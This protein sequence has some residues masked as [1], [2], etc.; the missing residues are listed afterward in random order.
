MGSKIATSK[1][2][3]VKQMYRGIKTNDLAIV[4]VARFCESLVL[5][6]INFMNF[7]KISLGEVIFSVTKTGCEMSPLVLLFRL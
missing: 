3:D 4:G 5:I 2:V 6:S 1:T 7:R